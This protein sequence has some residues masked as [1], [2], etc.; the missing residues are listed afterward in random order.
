MS[1]DDVSRFVSTATI[2]EVGD[3]PSKADDKGA[4]SSG[5]CRC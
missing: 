4:C 5:F 2:A 1:R 3:G